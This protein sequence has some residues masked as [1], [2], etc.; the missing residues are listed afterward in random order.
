MTSCVKKL[1]VLLDHWAAFEK[2]NDD[3]DLDYWLNV[4]KQEYEDDA[5]DAA[6][7]ANDADAADAAAA[8]TPSPASN[9]CIPVENYLEC[10]GKEDRGL[11]Y[12]TYCP[13]NENCR[14]KNVCVT[15]ASHCTGTKVTA[16]AENSFDIQKNKLG[17]YKEF[18]KIK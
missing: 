18:M 12:T 1:N 17:D 6:D 9:E 15:R 3:P 5:K 8:A 2:N 7:A 10:R 14:I 11:N 13:N 4:I 16:K